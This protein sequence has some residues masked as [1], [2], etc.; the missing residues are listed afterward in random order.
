MDGNTGIGQVLEQ[1]HTVVHGFYAGA[2]VYEG[3]YE[4]YGGLRHDL[5]T[6]KKIEEGARG[7]STT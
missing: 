3:R 7:P 4:G 5:A 1:P 2:D 6:Y